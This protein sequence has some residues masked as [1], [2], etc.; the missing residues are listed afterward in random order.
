M[1]MRHLSLLPLFLAVVLARPAW[2]WDPHGHQ[3]VGAIADRLLT[4]DARAHVDRLLGYDLAT[5]AKWPDCV[6]SVEL[7]PDGRF[8]YDST[9][10]YQKPCDPFMAPDEVARMEDYVKRNWSNC[11]GIER[12]CHG[13]YH[14][15]D[16]AIQRGGYR[17]SLAG[18]SDHDVV[19]AIEAAIDVLE[20]KPAPSPFAI[21]DKKEA[22]LLLAHFVGDLHQPLHVGAVYLDA[23]GGLVDPERPGTDVRAAGT[24]GGNAIEVGDRRLH[25]MWDEVPESWTLGS[26]PD[27]LTMARDVPRT[28]GPLS[29]WPP[30]WAGE[31]VRT[32]QNSF[33]G[34]SFG[35]KRDGVW[36][37]TTPDL[38]AYQAAE[39]RL[40]KQ[41]VAT[42][43]A[44][45]AAILNTLWP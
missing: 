27:L 21:K 18:T 3:L 32:A 11:P 8:V 26:M 39:A 25:E 6:R 22:L 35:A 23:A 33:A 2:C 16:V 14:Y 40:K 34:L 10:P 20:G 36:T 30:L 5:A 31:T 45:L 15:A 19:S 43:G 37:A 24:K 12:G 7:K 42:A 13:T 41:Q 1:A 44:R 4:P 29:A 38:L 9:T 17:R 28:P